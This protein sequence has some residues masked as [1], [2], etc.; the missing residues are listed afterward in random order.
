MN[1]FI[2]KIIELHGKDVALLIIDNAINGCSDWKVKE[3]FDNN[4]L[5][6]Y[7]GILNRA[8]TFSGTLQGHQYWAQ[9]RDSLC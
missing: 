4:S 9:I 2:N 7:Y 1:G 8:F 5:I 3:L 6:P